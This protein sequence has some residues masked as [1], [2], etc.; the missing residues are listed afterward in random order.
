MKTEEL[1]QERLEEFGGQ[2]L[3]TLNKAAVAL[4]MSIGHRTRLFSTMAE[5]G[6]TSSE[7][8]AE[9][10][11]LHER[12]VR[13]WL[14]AMVTGGIVDYDE[15]S[16]TYSLPPEHAAFLT[17][18]VPT[19]NMA[20]FAQL[21]PLLGKVE[22]EI[23]QCFQNGGGVPYSSYDRFPEVMRELSA[24]TFDHLLVDEILPLAPGLVDSLKSGIDVL[25]VGCGSGR[26][27][28]VLAEAFPNSR[29][30]GYDLLSVQIETAKTE[31]AERGLSNVHFDVKDVSTLD[32]EGQFDLAL[33][34]DT[35]HD[36]AQPA[37]M[38]EELFRALKG[39]GTFLMQ[40]VAASSHLHD[41]T[42]HMLGPFLYTVSCMHCMSVSLAQD[43][44]GLG[45]MWGQQK[46]EEMLKDAGF[47]EIQVRQLEDDPVNCCYLATRP[48]A[49][50][51]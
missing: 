6:E 34:F 8:I 31:A 47:V 25:E 10:S 30:V 13:E 12:Y 9:A 5:L 29:F 48:P 40:D 3:D 42:D 39:G 22:D 37:A 2:A 21:I 24:P 11:G 49:A 4:M 16:N 50:N 28:N 38:L 36:Q 18:E 51:H 41:N 46:A 1:N 26:A 27:L 43:G 35:V 20:N 23:V 7:E 33:A 14:G 32:H 19:D 17:P 44:V 15:D 45:A